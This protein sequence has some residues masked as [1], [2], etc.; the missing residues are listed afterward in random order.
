MNPEAKEFLLTYWN[1]FLNNHIIVIFT[2]L[3]CFKLVQLLKKRT[4]FYF[5]D[6]NE[7]QFAYYLITKKRGIK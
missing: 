1:L 5:V 6:T 3:M 2:L 4:E 7:T